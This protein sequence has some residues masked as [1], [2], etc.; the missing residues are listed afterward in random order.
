MKTLNQTIVTANDNKTQVIIGQDKAIAILSDGTMK[1]IKTQVEFDELKE[2]IIAI[3]TPSILMPFMLDLDFSPSEVVDKVI[4]VVGNRF[5][6]FAMN[7]A[8]N[9]AEK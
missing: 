8:T 5:M 7:R 4:D 6:K 1:S 3:T 2:N 9:K